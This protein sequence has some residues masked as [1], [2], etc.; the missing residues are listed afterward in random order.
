MENTIITQVKDFFLSLFRTNLKEPGDRLEAYVTKTKKQVIKTTSENI[1][2]SA[3]RYP[4]TGTIVETR[5]TREK[6]K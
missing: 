5:V 3:T 4:S 1:K 2:Y 6:R